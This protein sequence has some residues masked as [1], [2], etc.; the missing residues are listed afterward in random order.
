MLKQILQWK[1][2]LKNGRSKSTIS[3]NGGELE[4]VDDSEYLGVKTSKN[5]D[6]D[7]EVE[8]SH[9]REHN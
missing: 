7:A 9:A 2:I 6:G 8:S 4:V 1:I 5:G 3:L